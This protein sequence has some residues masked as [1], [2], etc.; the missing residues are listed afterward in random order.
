MTDEFMTWAGLDE[1]RW[2]EL[3]SRLRRLVETERTPARVLM[4][5]AENNETSARE[6]LVL[7]YWL[8]RL[9]IIS[10]QGTPMVFTPISQ[11]V[12]MN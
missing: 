12:G 7:S 5:L 11:I 8:G 10:E 4:V 2:N 3:Q 1:A 9:Q 6:S